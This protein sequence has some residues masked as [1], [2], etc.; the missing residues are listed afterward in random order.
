MP[1]PPLSV[2]RCPPFPGAKIPLLA[3]QD[4]T[5]TGQ[6]EAAEECSAL[7]RQHRVG[8]AFWGEEDPWSTFDG[9][10]EWH[11]KAD[12]ENALLARIAGLRVK[13]AGHGRFADCA[14][15][16]G[17]ETTT[18]V[19]RHVLVGW[20][21]VSPFDGTAT[22]ASK[23]IAQLGEWRRL[24][25]NNREIAGVMGVARWKRS[26]M[27]AML[28]DGM[29]G[30]HYV[31]QVGDLKRPGIVAVWKSRTPRAPLDA[32]LASDR[33]IAEIEDGFIR[34]AGLGADC[35]PPLSIVV[36]RQGIYFDP[37]QPSDLETILR[38]A[39]FDDETLTRA[40]A[41]RERLIVAGI[42][43]YGLDAESFVRPAGA[44]RHVLVTGQVEDDRS[45]LTG[46]AGMS[47]LD[48][49]RQARALEPDAYLI[50]KPHPDVEAGHRK[51]RIADSDALVFADLVERRAPIAGILASVEA[52]HVITSLAGFEGLMRGKEVVAHGAPFFAGWGVTTDLQQVSAR[53]TRR[54][55]IDELVVATLILYPIYFDPVSRLPCPV[56]MLV[57]RMEAGATAII[58][59]LVR[60]R[61]WQ[62]RL[63]LFFNAWGRRHD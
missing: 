14:S 23:T 33:Q 16:Q 4:A 21:F 59:P 27:T 55:K 60:L 18:L 63:N 12:D 45:V 2:L 30:P 44:R 22:S 13:L 34:S 32:L 38:H 8:G 24:I 15:D 42:S 43:K 29:H 37:G 17:H 9:K 52:I 35:I 50:Y 31:R 26:T 36:D 25:M 61:Q 46:G 19:E 47:N 51:G 39:N 48:L 20:R 54:R 6:Q 10:L 5:A 7:M 53:R 41:L 11:G 62:G 1:Q 58:T 49:L 3:V 28:W 57:Q 40:A 56:E